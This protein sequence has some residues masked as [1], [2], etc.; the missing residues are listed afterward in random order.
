M[1]DRKNSQ[2]SKIYEQLE[3]SKRQIQ[4]SKKIYL[5]FSIIK[6]MLDGHKMS[7]HVK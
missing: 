3:D 1:I 2:S 7:P 5:P 4:Q 6:I